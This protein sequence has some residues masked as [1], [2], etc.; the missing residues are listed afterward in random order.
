MD[1]EGI[2]LHNSVTCQERYGEDAHHAKPGG[3]LLHPIRQQLHQVGKN[4]GLLP[5]R[6]V[7][8]CTTS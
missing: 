2:F 6:K 5:R 3:I 1:R 7:L 4:D 8:Q